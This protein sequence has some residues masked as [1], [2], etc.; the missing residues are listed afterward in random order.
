L[1]TQALGIDRWW[2]LGDLVAIGPDPVGTLEL[3]A[4]LPHVD[5]ISGNTERYV[6]TSDRP[7]R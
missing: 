1:T 2:V 5:V 6:L 3:V 7:P 4:D